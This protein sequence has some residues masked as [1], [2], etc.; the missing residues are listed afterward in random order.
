MSSW[1][2]L[3]GY[4][5]PGGE[6]QGRQSVAVI[7]LIG[8]C[9]K[10]QR[11]QRGVSQPSTHALSTWNTHTQ[12][13]HLHP[14]TCTQHTEHVHSTHRACTHICTRARAVS[15]QNTHICT[16]ARALSTRNVHTQHTEH[17]HASAPVHVPSAHGTLRGHARP[18]PC[19]CT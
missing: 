13:A 15:T 4:R 14:C 2:P 10:T 18:H 19:T 7:G 17:A 11:E 9:P 8:L 1:C 3:L 12:H 16:H 5:G 6:G